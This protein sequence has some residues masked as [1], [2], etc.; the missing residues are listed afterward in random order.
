MTRQRV[1]LFGATAKAAVAR[2]GLPVRG[3]KRRGRLVVQR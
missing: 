2:E 3:W 1:R